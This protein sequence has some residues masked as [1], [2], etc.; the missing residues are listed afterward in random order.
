VKA[1]STTVEAAATTTVAT[2]S[3]VLGEGYLW[4]EKDEGEGRNAC[5]KSF[6]SHCSYLLTKGSAREV[7]ERIYRLIL[8]Y[9]ESYFATEV[10]RRQTRATAEMST[11][12]RSYA[13]RI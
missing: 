13:I 8:L 11:S 4:G 2:A 10:V 12:A 5:E 7:E 3:A 1:A 6:V 9:F